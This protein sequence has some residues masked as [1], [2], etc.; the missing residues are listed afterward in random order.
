MTFPNPTT[1]VV[2]TKYYDFDGELMKVEEVRF[3][4]DDL[5]DKQLNVL[6]EILTAGTDMPICSN[7]GTAHPLHNV[8]VQAGE[9][10]CEACIKLRKIT[11]P[12]RRLNK[13]R[14]TD[15][16]KGDTL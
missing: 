9:K 11:A 7:C 6:D 5:T 4:D 16:E 15:R 8:T 2:R 12:E 14:K 1:Y 10:I 13:R 3:T